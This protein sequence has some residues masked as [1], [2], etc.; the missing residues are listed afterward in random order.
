MLEKIC[1]MRCECLQYASNKKVVGDVDERM[2]ALGIGCA[3]SCTC[4][5]VGAETDE[6]EIERAGGRASGR[7]E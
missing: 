4:V 2:N 1:W 6:M 3:S 5:R 7:R